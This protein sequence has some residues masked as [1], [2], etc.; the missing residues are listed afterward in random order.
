VLLQCYTCWYLSRFFKAPNNGF[1]G[2]CFDVSCMFI[3]SA[4][5]CLFGSCRVACRHGPL[6]SHR[7]GRAAMLGLLAWLFMV[8]FCGTCFCLIRWRVPILGVLD[9]TIRGHSYRRHDRSRR[10][11]SVH[12]D[13]SRGLGARPSVAC[14]A[15]A[16]GA[17]YRYL[18]TI[19]YD[20]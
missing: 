8:I 2:S 20:L 7:T 1:K 5:T 18:H 14:R 3:V 11:L 6:L 19:Q 16:G 9:A 10:G 15:P 12:R 17:T 4:L 13:A